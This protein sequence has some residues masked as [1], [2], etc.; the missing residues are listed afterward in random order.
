V[1]VLDDGAGAQ[2]AV[3][4]DMQGRVM[5][6]T[7]AGSDGLCMGWINRELIASGDTLVHINAYGGEDRFWIG[8]E[9]GQFAVSSP[10][11]FISQADMRHW[12][13]EWSLNAGN[14]AKLWGKVRVENE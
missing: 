1:L 4:P 13:H 11:P 2:V 9:G 3:L 5:T 14:E 10:M 6:S 12:R 7:L 8:S